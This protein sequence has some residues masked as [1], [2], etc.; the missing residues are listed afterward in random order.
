MTPADDPGRP[1]GPLETAHRGER[2][3]RMAGDASFVMASE[4]ASIG[5]RYVGSILTGRLLGLAWFG[6][7]TLGLTV[8]RLLGTV[9]VLG[10]SPGALPFLAR[11]R[12][13][14]RPQ[15]VLAVV[16]AT[17]S[18]VAA[19]ALLVSAL[20]YAL[21]PW[22][23]NVVFDQPELTGILRPLC[24]LT[25]FSALTTTTTG[26]I[27]GLAG[28]RLQALI[29]RVLLTVVT[30]FV[31]G[32]AWIFDW[33]VTGV[34]G[35]S[36]AGPVIGLAVAALCVGR[37]VPGA[38]GSTASPGPG[39]AWKLTRESWPLMGMSL[40]AFVLT[41]MDVLLM[42]VFCSSE[43]V[44]LYGACARLAPAVVLVQNATG[45]VF[46]AQ[47][48]RHFVAGDWNAIRHLYRTTGLWCLWSGAVA[49]SI[50]LLWGRELLALFGPEFMAGTGVLAILTLGRAGS[51][52]FGMCGRMLSITGQARLA[53]RNMLLMIGSNAVLDLL[54]IP[55]WGALGAAA[56]T[57]LCVVGI[58][59]LQ[60]L[61]VWLLYRLH[62]FTRRSVLGLG[63][64]LALAGLAC[65]W[66]AGPG[67]PWGWLLPLSL[68][69]VA[70]AALYLKAG[71]GDVDRAFLRGLARRLRR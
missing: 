8:A 67:G 55:R 5:L 58:N 43:E 69:L 42:G 66:R 15:E 11:A 23:S 51:A 18:V 33:G 7:V 35:A 6:S 4:F 61:E 9:S 40:S 47:L 31:L 27:Q 36:I 19:F 56:A 59:A 68:F 32:L 14:G 12:Q 60:S 49:A 50:L 16:R 71:A 17:W 62:P 46:L 41:W 25:F 38:L 37:L 28:V 65:L 1:G 21:A 29:D 70:S 34:I 39:L 44:G 24:L 20:C 30:V 57:C 45:P 10:T 26:L 64:P 63:G 2:I 3:G 53:L 48:S 22:L 52:F 54:W 13:A